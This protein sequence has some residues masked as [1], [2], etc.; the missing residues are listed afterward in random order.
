MRAT[1]PATRSGGAVSADGA[2]L[3]T[4]PPTVPRFWIWND[5][6][7]DAPV[8]RAADERALADAEQALATAFTDELL[9]DFQRYARAAGLELSDIAGVQFNPLSFECRLG[10]APRI[11]YLAQFARPGTGG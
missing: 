6:T 4:L 10:G 8:A 9:P 11:N 5:P 7:S 1:A 2:A 3:H